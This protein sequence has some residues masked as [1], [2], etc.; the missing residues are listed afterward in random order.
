MDRVR[1]FT[2]AELSQDEKDDIGLLVSKNYLDPKVW[3]VENFPDDSLLRVCKR[4]LKEQQ[5]E[6]HD[7]V[8]PLLLLKFLSIHGDDHLLSHQIVL[9]V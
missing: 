2:E 5:G 6:F 7:S 4:A 3:T 8:Q 1:N 9:D